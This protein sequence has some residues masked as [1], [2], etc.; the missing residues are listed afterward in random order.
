MRTIVL[1]VDGSECGQKAM[2]WVAD[3]AGELAAEVIAVH[4]F[5]L[6]A[7]IGTHEGVYEYI[8]DATLLNASREIMEDV[9]VAPLRGKA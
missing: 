7:T 8:D 1:G 5:D 6:L 4:A 2:Q 9:W 3:L